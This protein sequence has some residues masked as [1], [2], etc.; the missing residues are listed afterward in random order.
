MASP[1]EQ[2]LRNNEELIVS[3]L[4]ILEGRETKAR[5]NLDGIMF[6][7]GKTDV[8]VNG[9]VEFT[10]VPPKSKKK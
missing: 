7:I 2:I 6:R 5:A 10:I 9:T 4:K 3:F 1:L 8:L